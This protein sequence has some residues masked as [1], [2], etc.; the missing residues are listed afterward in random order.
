MVKTVKLKIIGMECPN[1]AMLLEQIEDKLTG[2]LRAEASYRKAEFVVQY[3]ENKVTVDQI[4]LEVQLL[5]YQTS[6]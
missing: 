5:G 3:D 1:C 6:L 4:I 2:V